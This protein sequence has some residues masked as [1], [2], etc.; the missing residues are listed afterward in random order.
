MKFLLSLI[1]IVTLSLP[2]FSQKVKNQKP[3]ITVKKVEEETIMGAPDNDDAYVV[4]ETNEIDIDTIHIPTGKPCLIIIKVNQYGSDE[5]YCFNEEKEINQNF[6]K[7]SIRIIK[8]KGLSYVIFENKQ[9]LDVSGSGNSYQGYLYWSGNL[10]DKVKFED[11]VYFTTEF[12]AKQMGVDKKSSYVVNAQKYKKEVASLIK[13][14]NITEKSKEVMNAFLYN[15]II[16]PMPYEENNSPLSK[17]CVENMKNIEN[18]KGVEVYFIEK[19]GKKIFLRNMVFNNNQQPIL[20]KNYDSDGTE[21]TE[22]NY[23][24]KNGMLIKI[25]TGDSSIAITYDDDKM[26]FPTDLENDFGVI[27]FSLKNNLLLEKRYSL[28]T[29]DTYPF[30]NFFGEEK[31]ENNCITKYLNNTVLWINCSSNKDLFPFENKYTSF[32]NGEVMQYRKTKL[33]RKDKKLFEKYH[34]TAKQESAKD[35]FKLFSVYHLNDQN[36]LSS[37]ESIED[38]VKQNIKINY[39]YFPKI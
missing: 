15:F 20:S 33:I 18:L 23:I 11:T 29:E 10:K 6:G 9:T 13:A 5:S 8:L 27:V 17:L 32:Q 16:S 38:S 1:L 36:L 22:T 28:R 2:G 24:Y 25:I 37:Y 30:F 3:K 12:V 14:D 34:S 39:T 4:Q 26:I 21:K 7:D 19:S 35:D 31:I